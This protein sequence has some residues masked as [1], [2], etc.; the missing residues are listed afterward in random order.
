M[1]DIIGDIHGHAY[2]LEKLLLK[3]GYRK[4]NGC[5]FHSERKVVFVGDFID[6]GPMIREALKIAR[7]MTE[8]GNALAVIGNHEYNALCYHTKNERG[9]WMRDHSERK[10]LQHSET[11]KQFKHHVKE[12][13]CLLICRFQVSM[14]SEVLNYRSLKLQKS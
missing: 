4:K 7:S 13:I 10:M 12:K 11:L 14:T 6:R 5:Y 3:M 8:N 1:Y 2:H 9:E